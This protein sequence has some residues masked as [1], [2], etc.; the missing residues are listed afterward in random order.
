VAAIR[1]CVTRRL[2]EGATRGYGFPVGVLV[3]LSIGGA[4][5]H[6]QAQPVASGAAPHV[7]AAEA[8]VGQD[9]VARVLFERLCVSGLG[10][11]Q[12]PGHQRRRRARSGTRSR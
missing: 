2:Q 3:V 1:S 8:A 11:S 12:P 9:A 5:A 6:A 7:A 4:S 10:L